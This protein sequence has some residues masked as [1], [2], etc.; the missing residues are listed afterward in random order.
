MGCPEP[1]TQLCQSM[2]SASQNYS[3]NVYKCGQDRDNSV[4]PP[5]SV[6]VCKETYFLQTMRSALT[7]VTRMN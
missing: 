1:I 3:I 2:S 4:S 7:H 5:E 6:I